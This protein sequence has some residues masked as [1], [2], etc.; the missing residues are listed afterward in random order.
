MR[1]IVDANDNHR[2]DTG[3]Y[4]KGVEPEE[5]YYDPDVSTKSKPRK[6]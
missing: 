2:W 6:A 1:V 3:D 4:D 5:V